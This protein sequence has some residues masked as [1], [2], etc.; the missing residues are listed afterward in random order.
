[1]GSS[2]LDVLINLA[3]LDDPWLPTQ[4]VE[5][6]VENW[7]LL[8]QDGERKG[9]PDS[10]LQPGLQVQQNVDYK[11]GDISAQGY[12]NIGYM[13]CYNLCDFNNECVGY[14]YVRKKS[15]CW[16]KRELL[17]SKANPEVVSGVK[18]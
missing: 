7:R 8:E 14:S 2:Q 13:Q 15:W 12:R 17:L 1:M 18:K 9:A 11:G 5:F 4:G 3:Y 10:S 16:L 6:E